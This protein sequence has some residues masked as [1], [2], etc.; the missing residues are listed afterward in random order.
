MIKRLLN[1]LSTKPLKRISLRRSIRVLTSALCIRIE[2]TN[3]S[4]LRRRKSGR[5][6]RKLKRRNSRR[7]GRRLRN[8][9]NEMGTKYFTDTIGDIFPWASVLYR[10]AFRSSF[11][12]K[13]TERV[14]ENAARNRISCGN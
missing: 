5:R 3:Y 13:L 11:A 1:D 7:T 6:L 2:S 9:S 8:G 10:S 4:E 12:N 14:I